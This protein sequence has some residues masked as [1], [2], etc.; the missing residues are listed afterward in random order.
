MRKQTRPHVKRRFSESILATFS[1]SLSLSLSFASKEN[2]LQKTEATDIACRYTCNIYLAPMMRSE[3]RKIRKRDRGNLIKKRNERIS[4]P[5]SHL[6][7]SL[8]HL[9]FQSWRIFHWEITNDTKW[10]S[11]TRLDRKEEKDNNNGDE[12]RKIWKK[13]VA[14]VVCSKMNRD[15]RYII[16]KYTSL[17]YPLASLIFNC[18]KN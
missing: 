12:K 8:L 15:A 2:E 18:S 4:P 14:S 1:L 17:L 3:R 6:Y 9:T 5:F 16:S 13:S 11:A 10:G 7:L